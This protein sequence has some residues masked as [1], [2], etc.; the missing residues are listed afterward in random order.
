[1]NGSVAFLFAVYLGSFVAGQILLKRA[2]LANTVSGWVTRAVAI[3]FAAAI[4]A[5]TLSFF[6]KVGLLQRF[7]LS[8]VYPFQGLTVV[9]I[10]GTSAILLSEKLTLRFW[11]GAIIVSVGVIMV[12]AT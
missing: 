10:A 7:D 12:S 5:M 6:V 4:A 9:L 11:L 8:Y 3:P 2:M 1:M